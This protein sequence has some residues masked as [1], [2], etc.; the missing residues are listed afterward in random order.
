MDSCLLLKDPGAEF[1]LR[2]GV[3]GVSAASELL[4]DCPCCSLGAC[5][6]SPSLSLS[7]SPSPPHVQWGWRCSRAALRG[8]GGALGILSV[9]F[10][11]DE[12]MK[13]EQVLLQAYYCARCLSPLLVQLML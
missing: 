8:G 13:Q 3:P 6:P 9:G 4:T 10:D 12:G 2:L 7:P 5:V 1:P 11:R